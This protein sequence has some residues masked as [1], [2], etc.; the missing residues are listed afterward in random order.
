MVD[1]TRLGTKPEVI[2]SRV[3]DAIP[4]IG[5]PVSYRVRFAAFG[6]IYG[7]VHPNCQ[8]SDGDIDKCGDFGCAHPSLKG[9]GYCGCRGSGGCPLHY[10]D[11]DDLKTG[12]DY[13]EYVM[14]YES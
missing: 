10:A 8:Y 13:A 3:W 4:E 14:R 12:P 7:R 2:D 1:I 5:D 11:K 9:I 6:S